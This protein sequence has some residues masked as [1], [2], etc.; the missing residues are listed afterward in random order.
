VGNDPDRPAGCYKTSDGVWFNEHPTG[1][2]DPDSA[3]ICAKD[4]EPVVTG[5]V[6]WIGDSDT[7]YWVNTGSIAPGSHNVAVGGYTCKDVLNYFDTML[8]T[9]APSKSI[10]T[11]GEND[12]PDATVNQAFARFITIADKIMVKGSTLIAFGTKDEPD[13][14]ELWQK[15][16]DYDSR[17]MTL[18]ES[19][20]TNVASEPSLVFV[21]V[22]AGFKGIGNHS[23]LYAGD[24]LHLSSEGYALWDT[25]ASLALAE[26]EGNASCVIWR[27]EDCVLNLQGAQSSPVAELTPSTSASSAEVSISSLLMVGVVA[28]TSTQ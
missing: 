11:C 14:S 12:L 9:F 19:I 28:I 27:S 3:V 5:G 24:G 16:A 6:L 1:G 18:T 23:S 2:I 4:M 10:M 17:I 7:D 25:W 8:E 13:T 26:A 20:S 22:N 21:D 15:Y